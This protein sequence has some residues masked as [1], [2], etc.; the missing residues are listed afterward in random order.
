MLRALFPKFFLLLAALGLITL[1]TS[2]GARNG[3]IAQAVLAGVT[4]VLPLICWALVPAT[5][6]A[7]D[8]GNTARFK[9]LHLV[10]VLLTVVVLLAN[11]A[12]PLVG[13]TG[14][15]GNIIPVP[16]HPNGPTWCS[17]RRSVPEHFPK[18]PP[19]GA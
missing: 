5:N 6:R 19:E 7:T 13:A 15:S 3:S 14:V 1:L 12:I 9:K 2:F 8:T 18:P 17:P 10:S 16:R 4:I 11:I